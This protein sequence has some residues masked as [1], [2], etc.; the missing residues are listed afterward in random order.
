MIMKHLSVVIPC[1]DE[2]TNLQKNVL[3]KVERFLRKKEYEYEV[4]V[5]DDGSTDGSIEFLEEFVKKNPRFRLLKGEHLGK[6]GAVTKGMLE[7]KGKYRIFADMDQATPI[8]EIDA[9]LPYLETGEFDI[10]IGSRI[11]SHKGYPWSRLILHEG[12]IITRKVVVGL[13]DLRDTQCGFKMFTS[14]AAE[15]LFEKVNTLHHGFSKISGSAVTAG[16]DVE[17]LK[18]A[19]KM[20]YKIKEVPVD[21]LYVET[22]RVSPLKDSI[23]AI[24]YLI[25]IRLNDLRGY[26]K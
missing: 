24:W 12:M 17:L 23:E 25:Q 3:E 18:I 16:F 26:Y 7:A 20:G 19:T 6:A 14:E 15:K 22:R 10:A 21:W 5:V 13:S 9:L 1:F 8:Q 2:M 4:I 11:S